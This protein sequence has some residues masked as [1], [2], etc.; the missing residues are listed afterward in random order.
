M[1]FNQSALFLPRVPPQNLNH[2]LF[3]DVFICWICPSVTVRKNCF[4]LW[5]DAPIWCFKLGWMKLGY[6]HACIN[7]KIYNRVEINVFL[8]YILFERFHDLSVSS[9]QYE[10]CILWLNYLKFT[11]YSGP[12]G[13]QVFYCVATR[14]SNHFYMARTTY[15]INLPLTSG[16][17]M[18]SRHY[19]A[20]SLRI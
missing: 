8:S 1:A 9:Y 6:I 11:N 10:S 13:M 3:C 4:V 19:N 14:V 18:Y 12:S 5:W 2:H 15:N 20:R 7:Y 17:P 16:Y